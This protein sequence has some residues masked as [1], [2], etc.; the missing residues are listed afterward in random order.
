[1]PTMTDADVSCSDS[2]FS[3]DDRKASRFYLLLGVLVAGG[4]LVASLFVLLGNCGTA[5]SDSSKAEHSGFAACS[6]SGPLTAGRCY[7]GVLLTTQLVLKIDEFSRGQGEASVWATSP[8]PDA[9]RTCLRK[10]FR[11]KGQWLTIEGELAGCDLPD[12]AEYHIQY[13]SNTDQIHVR[14]SD[15]IVVDVAL[16]VGKC[17]QHT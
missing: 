16:Q 12:G 1:M 15:P 17:V 10:G 9:S 3:E 7:Q 11:K 5:D 4:L 6:G 2:D 14:V 8:D 13:C